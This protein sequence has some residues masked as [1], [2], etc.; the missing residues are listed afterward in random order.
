MHLPAS[1]PMV[2]KTEVQAIVD[3]TQCSVAVKC[4]AFMNV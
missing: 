4:I 3:V 2:S 1:F